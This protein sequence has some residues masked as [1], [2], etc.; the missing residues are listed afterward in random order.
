MKL[1]SKKIENVST[2]ILVFHEFIVFQP[3]IIRASEQWF[4]DT[5]KVSARAEELVEG[6]TVG[7]GDAGEGRLRYP[8]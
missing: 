5:S 1:L 2:R 6:I 4:I 8:E 7:S 3:V